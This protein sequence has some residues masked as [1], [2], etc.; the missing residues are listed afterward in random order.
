MA[1]TKEEYQ[2]FLN[3]VVE[4]W[5]GKIDDLEASVKPERKTEVG[6]HEQ[7]DFLRRKQQQAQQ[8]L[9]E[10]RSTSEDWQNL[11]KRA[12]ETLDELRHA[13]ERAKEAVR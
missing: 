6:L 13:F 9:D 10:L 3:K 4:E 1:D 2:E 11:K 5:R 12:D 8:H 7:V